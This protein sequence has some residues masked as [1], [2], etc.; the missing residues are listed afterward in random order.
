M[1]AMSSRLS[2]ALIVLA[3]A[4]ALFAWKSAQDVPSSIRAPASQT[5]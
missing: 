5:Y 1:F 2:P 3:G 4:S